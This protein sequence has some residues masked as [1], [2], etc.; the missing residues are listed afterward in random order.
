MKLSLSS[1]SAF[2]VGLTVKKADAYHTLSS[3]EYIMC[4]LFV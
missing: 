4:L 3:G 2:L 1:I